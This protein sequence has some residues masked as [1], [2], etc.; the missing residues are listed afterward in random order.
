MPIQFGPE[1]NRAGSDSIKWKRYA[2]QDI[3]PMWVADMDFHV[4]TE[5]TQA[6]NERSEHGVLGY[7]SDNPELMNLIVDH[8]QKH[9]QW[10]IK[11][12]WIVLTPGVVKGLNIARA[13]AAKKGKTAG[14]TALPVYP[15]LK[16]N[17][18]I[19]EF[20]NQTFLTRPHEQSWSL[21]LAEME[22]NITDKTGVMLLCNPHNPIGKVYSKQELTQLAELCAKHDLIICSD[23]IHCDL[24]L[25]GKPHIPI[26]SLS[27]EVAQCSITLM[28]PSKTF[29]I[30]G[31]DT[32]FAVIPNPKMRKQ[33]SEF[34]YGLVGHVNII[35]TQA[36]IAAY[37][38]G[39]PWRLELIEY[40]KKNNQL[41]QERIDSIKGISM[42]P[43]EA[44]YLAWLNVEEL[45]L[46]N[47]QKYFEEFG[48]GM[49]AGAEF[50]DNH[51]VRL[52][53][54]CQRSLLKEALNRIEKAVEKRILNLE[55]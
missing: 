44:T 54:G 21:D 31:L 15:H 7:G 35:G 2:N 53:F 50:G 41:I 43:V 30:A 36:A 24:I 49:S 8:C 33:Y 27:E 52:N 9:Y 34:M 45:E 38:Y 55:K 51:Y 29:N 32:A 17:A 16:Q 20:E 26:A 13:M 28:A 3:L 37:K 14:I 18:P 11:P 19:I 10:A 47:P 22:K 6:I 46:D 48:V 25:N 39:E 1:V 4:A 5:I 40:L 12:E 42:R 23:D